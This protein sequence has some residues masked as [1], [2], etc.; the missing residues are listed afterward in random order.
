LSAWYCILRVASLDER[1][2]WMENIKST[3]KK[4]TNKFIS[5]FFFSQISFS[6]HFISFFP[7]SFPFLLGA[8]AF[9]TPNQPETPKTT[10]ESITTLAPS[11]T[12]VGRQ[13]PEKVEK[14]PKKK[15]KLINNN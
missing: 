10:R 14:Q 12:I 1:S 13:S 5:F 2:Q 7:L 4:H 8:I 3:K 15:V 9:N 11:P 6:F